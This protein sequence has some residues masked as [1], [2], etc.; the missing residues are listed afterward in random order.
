MLCIKLIGRIA[1]ALSTSL[2]GGVSPAANPSQE[3]ASQLLFK[4]PETRSHSTAA[5]FAGNAGI[6]SICGKLPP[7][8][9]QNIAQSMRIF[10]ATVSQALVVDSR[11]NFKLDTAP[12]GA[13]MA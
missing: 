8:L 4:L 6:Q 9:I 3:T 7:C 11:Q 12:N 10:Y 1:L 13:Q 2:P 5:A